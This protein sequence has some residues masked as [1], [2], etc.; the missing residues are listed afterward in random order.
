MALLKAISMASDVMGTHPESFALHD[1]AES[2]KYPGVTYA[3]IHGQEP[4]SRTGRLQRSSHIF[5]IS[6][7]HEEPKHIMVAE[8]MFSGDQ[9][10][11][12][13][14]FSPE[15]LQILRGER[16]YRRGHWIREQM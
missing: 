16:Y 1:I 8:E 13:H 6:E 14:S 11:H 15:A 3:T 2:E 5:D 10:R 7:E 4:P 9:W 12:T